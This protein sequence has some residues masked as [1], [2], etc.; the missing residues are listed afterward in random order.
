MV[1][2]CFDFFRVVCV[3][4]G[5][6]FRSGERFSQKLSRVEKPTSI[7]STAPLGKDY[8]Y[9]SVGNIPCIIDHLL[10]FGF[11]GRKLEIDRRT[12]VLD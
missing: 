7:V 1:G 10:V 12:V 2:N 5:I 6:C 4:K 3:G 9:P 11:V 8:F